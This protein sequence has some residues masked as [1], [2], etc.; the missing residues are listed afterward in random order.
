MYLKKMVKINLLYIEKNLRCHRKREVESIEVK[1][2]FKSVI[3]GGVNDIK[4]IKLKI[5]NFTS[6]YPYLVS[7]LCKN[8]DE[9]LE[10]YGTLKGL[11]KS[12]E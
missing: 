1:F 5:R 7:R 9:Y 12:I 6:G 10:K 11:R 3:L 4:N 8:I 2:N